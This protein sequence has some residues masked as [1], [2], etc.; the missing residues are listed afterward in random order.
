MC[1]VKFPYII[2]KGLS[3]PIIPVSIYG[4]AGWSAIEAYVDSGAWFSIFSIK[5]ADVLGLNYA[6]G[7]KIYSMVGDG[8]LI[9]VYLH[10]LSVKIGDVPFK[11]SIGFSPR[12]GIGFNLIGRKDFFD[13]FE[14]TFSDSTKT[15]IF[16]P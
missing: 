5:E 9:P 13:N 2:Y 16:S 10:K 11:A 3:H 8:S 6:K 12:L 1:P 14:I 7:R 4:P 15:I